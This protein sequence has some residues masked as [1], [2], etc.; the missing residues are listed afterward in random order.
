MIT[1]KQKKYLPLKRG[2]DV[3]LSGGAIVVLSPVLGL[4]A[5]AIKLDTPGPVLFKQKRVGKDKEL[6]EIY[7]FRTMRTDTPSDMPTHMLKDPD[8]FITKT[9]KFLRKTSLDELPQ[10][11]NIFIGKMSIIGPRPALW[12][13]DD[14][15]AERDKYH[16][17]DVTPGLTGWAQI[18]GRD[19]LEIDV[20]AKFDGDYIKEMG[21]KMDIKCFLATIGSVLLHDG[22]VEGGTGELKETVDTQIVDPEKIDKEAKIGA[23]VVG[24]A[25]VVGLTGLRL[26]YKHC[27]NKDN[28]KEKNS[29]KKSLLSLILILIS[30][31]SLLTKI[32]VDK[33]KTEDEVKKLKPSDE[34]SEKNIVGKKILL[35]SPAFFGYEN[36]IKEKMEKMGANVD[37]Y[38]VRSVTS[39]KGRALLKISPKIFEKKSIKYYKK[40]LNDNKDKDYDYILIVKCDMTPISV[41][42]NM[43]ELYP[44]AKLCLYLW[45][46]IDNIPGILNKFKYFD[47]LHSFDLE[48]CKKYPIL[49]FRPLFYCDEYK[50]EINSSKNYKYDISF[51]G[52][53]HSD[54]YAVIKE[55]DEFCKSKNYTTFWFK[56]LQSKFVYKLFKFAKKEYK[57]TVEKDFNFEKMSSNDI[58]KIVDESEIILDIQHPKQTGLTMRT[59]EMVGMNKKIIT[60]NHTIKEYDFYNPNNV[61]IIDRKNIKLESVFFESQYEPL[62]NQIYIKY[63]LEQWIKD[64]LS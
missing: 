4:L 51:L 23:T 3:V 12:N 41:L 39:A 26:T 52:T 49:K 7:K 62:S 38:D 5:L 54:R 46:S 27:K 29:R 20:K 11:F 9:G 15:V 2:I 50:K 33:K 37:M 13:Q 19:E 36:K 25:G 24:T 6:F 35:F 1:D 55:I 47:T 16:A 17:N 22:V 44:K 42:K 34:T 45:D 28:K 59:I 61:Y 30:I 18:N 8:Q 63:S 48:D 56:Y 43:K 31:C 21:L 10:I 53:I 57:N 60:T 14:L 32:F 64:I 58:A 40:I